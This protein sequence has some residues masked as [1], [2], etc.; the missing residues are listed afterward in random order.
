MV[1]WRSAYDTTRD[2]WG[3]TRI[4]NG[5]RTNPHRGVDFAVDPG[6]VVPAYERGKVV[7]T[8]YSPVLGYC[9][10]VQYTPTLF[11]GWAHLQVGTRPNIDTIVYP[12]DQ[13]GLVAGWTDDH[14]TAWTGPHIHTTLG[15]LLSSIFSGTTYDPLPRIRN[16][17]SSLADSGISRP[18]DTEEEELSPDEH[19]WLKYL[20]DEGP[21]KANVKGEGVY[22][23]ELRERTERTEKVANAALTAVN[24]ALNAINAVVI[25][26]V[27][28]LTPG[29]P[30]KKYDGEAFVVLKD[31]AADLE[32][33]K[34]SLL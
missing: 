1:D 27:D 4:V 20:F 11:G 15:P 12:G 26:Q 29:I 16:A 2:L 6:D 28:R 31:V 24:S 10:V 19:N 34:K 7:S 22:F 21:G 30:G 25:P 23:R 3:V 33:L 8:P 9:T 32:E 17:I 13:V 18:I 14:G 5:V